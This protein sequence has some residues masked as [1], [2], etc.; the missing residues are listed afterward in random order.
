[1]T[2]LIALETAL[3]LL[4]TP[5][6]HL[7]VEPMEAAEPGRCLL[8]EATTRRIAAAF[9]KGSAEG[10]LHL[11]TAEAQTALPSAFSFWKEFA[12]RFLT[13]LCHIPETAGE[14]MSPVPPP[15]DPEL[16]RLAQAAPPM[17][18]SEYLNAGLM[19][20]LWTELDRHVRGEVAASK[21]GLSAWLQ[22]HAPLWHRIGRVCFHL[23]EN[24]RDPD[25]P[26]AFLATYAPRVSSQG[27]VQYQPLS[28]ALEEYAGAK[29]KAGLE[30]LLTPV[31]RA[32]EKSALAR[33]LVDS[34]E[35]FHPLAWTAADAYRFLQDAPALEEAGLLLRVPDW[36]KKRPRPAVRVTV[37][38]QVSGRF[39]AGAMLDFKVEAA[40]D[41]EALSD[42]EWR[43]LLQAESGLVLL[44]GRWVE[45]DREKLAQAMAHWEKVRKA[46]RDE[47]ITFLEAMRLLSGAPM[48]MA[49]ADDN[50]A[51]RQWAFVEAGE[52]LAGILRELRDP[53]ALDDRDLGKDLKAELRPYQ[54]TGVEWLRFLARMGLGACLA[55]DMGLGK[56]IQVLALLLILKREAGN[57]PAQARPS[58]IVLPASLLA[59]WRAEIERFAPSLA[60]KFIHPAEMEASEIA[61]ISRAPAKALA[62]VDAA[63]TSYGMLLRQPWLKDVSWR[64][65]VLDEAQAIKNPSARQTRAVKELRADARLGL[66][67]TPIEN[68]LTDLWSLFDF[69]CPGLLGSLKEFDAFAR[70]LEDRQTDSYAPLRALARP[71][72]LRRLKTDPTVI[73][74]LPDK[75]EVQAFCPLTR[76]Q[77][78]LYQESVE[79]L[80]RRLEGLDGI[81][82]KG[83]ILAFLLRFKQICNHPAQWLGTGDYA[84]GESGKFERLREITEEIASRQDKVLVF[85]QFREMTGPIA[86][87]LAGVFGRPGAVLH[88][89]VPVKKRKALVDAFQAEDGPPFFVLSL[90]AGG[91]G[92]N[93]TAASHVVHFDR[94]WNPAVENQAT[95]RAFRI[96]QKRNVM[97]HKF[98][99]RGTIEEKI[100]ALIRD[101]TALAKDLLEAGAQAMMTEMKDDELLKFVALDVHRV[102]TA[103]DEPGGL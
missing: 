13:A 80:R 48:D 84:P 53:Q 70:A 52:T 91:T 29:N 22:E 60:V 87:F 16:D 68:R 43:R 89:A 18:G 64:L 41:G 85:T 12:G 69:L 59:N 40:L 23:A 94:W 7:R 27:R 72:I 82:R 17:R 93:L 56:T 38:D 32:A 34:G 51:A 79:E 50:A 66:T 35:V 61:A 20:A 45:V 77:A 11:A 28:R 37:G 36:W 24:K 46:A 95:D 5:A 9:E 14:G 4:V 26:F 103:G 15:E 3:E 96:G 54:R 81:E 10:L 19:T 42:A 78:A 25:R 44:K 30:K 39:G 63:F 65:A 86:D 57:K 21:G 8:P 6:G 88:G 100:D 97:V 49:R 98:V 90:K 74:D 1:M 47:G 2:E 99:C 101:K 71:Y 76:K 58:I 102:A 92:L 33:E 55:D 83:A 62:G 31:Q 75:T 67:G 73:S